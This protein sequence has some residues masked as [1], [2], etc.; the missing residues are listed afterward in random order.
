M[1]HHE[2]EFKAVLFDFDGVLGQTMEDNFN[3]WQR[4]VQDYGGGITA[5]DYYPMEGMNLKSIAVAF[6]EKNGL[7]SGGAEAMVAKK[8]SYYLQHHSFA[9]YPGAEECITLLK[10]AGIPLG[11]VTAGLGPR[12]K[13][14]LPEGFLDNFNVM[15]YGDSTERG[16]PFPDPYLH[17]AHAL[18][19]DCA[20]CIV[21]ENAPLG[22]R[23]AKQAG[24]YCIAIASTMEKTLLS[25]ADEI[26]NT[27]AELKTVPTIT[28]LL[29]YYEHIQ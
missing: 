8:E 17:A 26:I 5:E 11:M 14:T 20:R 6:C 4:A 1:P 18:N 19:I 3:A 21:I 13:K 10:T 25:E 16:K 28:H 15:V 22:I 27:I 2:K 9:L 7:D 23:S 24:A 29:H 12:L